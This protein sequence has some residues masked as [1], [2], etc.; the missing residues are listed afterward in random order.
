MVVTWGRML[1]CGT[2]RLGNISAFL[3]WFRHP[4]RH[5][6]FYHACLEEVIA[7]DH[8]TDVLISGTADYGALQQ[9]YS[10]TPAEKMRRL[11]I[12]V[13]D[14]C[15]TPLRICDW[16]AR[17]IKQP[18]QA[19][20]RLLPLEE[21]VLATNF[22]DETVDVIMTDAFLTRF[23]SDEKTRVVME[24]R[25]ILKPGGVVV[26]TARISNGVQP[27]QAGTIKIAGTRGR[28]LRQSGCASR[29]GAW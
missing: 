22:P 15:S 29:A 16:Y 19:M 10:A 1:A 14:L 25:R 17:T 6:G 3:I 11:K 5:A 21:D 20:P 9:I 12:H 26:T 4:D 8:V 27:D 2:I 28:R 24:W 13:L 23:S 7:R 18:G